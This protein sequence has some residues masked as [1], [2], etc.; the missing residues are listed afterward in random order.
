MKHF[1]RTFYGKISLI[2]VI[3]LFILGTI[4][5]VIS[6]QS[7]LNFVC[8]TDQ[9]INRP[10]AKNLA[11]KFQPHLIDS[12]DYSAIED[13]IHEIM[14]FNP[15]ID[16]YILDFNGKLKAKFQKPGS[17][18]LDKIDTKPIKDFI[19]NSAE[20]PLPIMGED[21]KEPDRHRVFSATEIDLGPEGKGYLYVIL[22]AE[23]FDSAITGI[24]GSYILGTTAFIF[25]ITL[26]FAGVL[27]SMLFFKLTKRLRNVTQTVKEFEQGNYDNRLIVKNDD[28]VGQLTTAFN[29]M[30]QTIELNMEELKKN[31]TLRR[32]LIA[33]I[34]HDLRSPLASIQG[35]IETILMKDDNIDPQQRKDFL[36]TILTSVTNLNT[37]VGELFELSK[38]D[39]MKSKPNPEPFSV[40]E[41]LQD[42]IL[43]FQPQAENKSINIITKI[44]RN[45]T[46]VLGDISMIDR[47][48]SNLIDNAIRYTADGGKISIDLKNKD[49]EIELKVSDT[50]EGIPAEDLPHV[51]DRFYRVEKS[52]TKNSGGSGLGLAIVKKIVEAHES[53]I[54]VESKLNKGT[55][56]SFTLKKN[57]SS[58]V[59]V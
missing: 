57:Q 22:G 49:D 16:V 8:E 4:Q 37:L 10:L 15:R 28:E 50:G 58:S 38:L 53:E 9:T 47:V 40:A 39:A 17:I 52:R 54:S 24:A 36:E 19:S 13:V 14:I 23:L 34:S 20:I 31:D 18:K 55:S 51:F 33:N 30:A 1:F 7:S 27:G 44:P 2:F 43:K 32:E 21:P 25:G 45:L 46:F 59:T 12:I 56:F 3:L 6:L 42:I 48:L 29:H 11:Q 41:L 35:Y 5:I 26:L